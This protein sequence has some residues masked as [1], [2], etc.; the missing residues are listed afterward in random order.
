MHSNAASDTSEPLTSYKPIIQTNLDDNVNTN[1][2]SPHS[3]NN[4]R[5]GNTDKLDSTLQSVMSTTQ[6]SEH[7]P[8]LNGNSELVIKGEKCDIP[9]NSSVH[10]IDCLSIGDSHNLHKSL[11]MSSVN[12]ADDEFKDAVD[13][14]IPT[15]FSEMS[16]RYVLVLFSIYWPKIGEIVSNLNQ[17]Y[18]SHI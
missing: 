13:A 14:K 11:S 12:S 3:E 16:P 7:V 2:P 8:P 4:L 1:I 18:S 5:T 10:Q 17:I 15:F 6:N 9:V